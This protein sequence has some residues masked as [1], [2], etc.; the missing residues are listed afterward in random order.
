MN[1]GRQLAQ[2]VMR[3]R[4]KF[5]EARRRLGEY[6]VVKEVRTPLV[7]AQGLPGARLGEVVLFE[8]NQ[9]GQVTALTERRIE[10]L[11]LDNKPVKT[12]SE[13]ARTGQPLDIEIG[14]QARGQI[15]DP[16]GT[17]LITENTTNKE[18]GEK[19]QLDQKPLMIGRRR[20]ITRQLVTGTAIVDL[21]LPIAEGQRE[22]VLGDQKTGKTLFTLAALKSYAE[23]KHNIVVYAAIGKPWRLILET[24]EFIRQYNV[25]N[26]VIVVASKA[27]DVASLVTLTPMTAMTIAEYYR[28]QG[29]NVLLVLDDMTTHAKY[30]RELSLLARRFPGRESYPGDIFHV[31]AR[32]LERAGKFSLPDSKKEVSIT[33][34]PVGETV[35]NDLAGYIV[36]NLISI[37]DGHMLFDTRI[38]NKG[39]RPAVDYALSVTRVGHQTRGHLA[40]KIYR[41]ISDLLT[42]HGKAQA[43]THFGAELSEDMRQVLDKGN[44]MVNFFSQPPYL[45]VPLP[46]QLTLAGMILNGWLHGQ[47]D[48][49]AGQWRDRL[50]AQLINNKELKAVLRDL[51]EA[52]ELRDFYQRLE[53]N[54]SYLKNICQSE[55]VLPTK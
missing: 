40:K 3:T 24:Y 26:N 15:M 43:Y 16:L 48:E 31:H 1:G 44:K 14:D 55:T 35:N 23:N 4:E 47:E 28:D 42:S 30:Y 11:L 18:S 29:H 54:K 27:D 36:S 49:A 7:S 25:N 53:E 19:R 6:G 46:A 13:I 32:L 41:E 50:A 51:T 45:S 17:R 39:R 52:E 37:T 20:K 9:A 2:G 21:L 38:F 33:C 34:L 10:I 12:G 8:N 5:S 22:T